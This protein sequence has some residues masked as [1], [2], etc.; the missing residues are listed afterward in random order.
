MLVNNIENEHVKFV[1]YTGRYP[2]LCTGVLILNIDGTDYVFGYDY[3]T[4]KESDFPSFWHSGGN[5]G[6]SSDYSKE[7]CNRSEWIIEVNGIPEQFRKYAA[8]IDRVFN[9][10]VE[11]GCCGGCL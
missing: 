2:N 5:C 6:F 4:Q 9:E 10:N 11:Y 1:S 3:K 8:E 7:Y